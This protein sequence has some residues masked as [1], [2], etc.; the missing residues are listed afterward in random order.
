MFL[1]ID[2]CL[3]VGSVVSESQSAFV[4][5]KQILYGILIANEI[6]DEASYM[7]KEMILFKVDFEKAYDSVDLRYLDSVMVNMNIPTLWRK[8]IFECVGTATAS[9]FVNECPTN[10]FP[11]E[12]GLRQGDPL[13]PFLFL[14]A[15]EGFNVLMFAVVGVQLFS[16]YEVGQAG[17][18]RLTH[19]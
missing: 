9:V 3:V 15:A 12:R 14:L 4:K 19:L 8:W 16:G 11:I 5:G 7:H 2:L 1:L 10:E 6:V 18:M 13:S 17:D